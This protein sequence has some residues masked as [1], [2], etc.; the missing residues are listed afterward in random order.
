MLLCVKVLVLC[1]NVHPCATQTEPTEAPFDGLVPQ[2]RDPNT[3]ILKFS[4]LPI[5]VLDNTSF[6]RYANVIGI[7]MYDCSITYVKSGT[8]SAHWRLQVVSLQ[9]NKI[10]EFS[11]NFG[12]A[13]QSIIKIMLWAAFSLRRLQP[14][15]FKKFPKL[16]Y[17]NLGHNDWTPFDPSIL[18][19]GLTSINLNYAYGLTTFPN[20]TNWTPNLKI[21]NI[22]RNII[23][24]IPPDNVRNMTINY[25]NIGGNRLT[26]IP[27]YN[28]Y[29]YINVLHLQ[30][31]KLTTVPDF[32]N[33]TLKQLRIELNPLVCDYA[34]CWIRMW[35]WMFDTPL[36]ADTPIC[37]SPASVTGT[38]LME[39]HPIHME[40]FNGK[41]GN[42]S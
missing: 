6:V 37:A 18:P 33:T 23:Q 17:L 31:N 36:L 26:S 3:T 12:L 2:D 14:F 34:L 25:I 32:Y 40:C 22:Y 24:E 5:P 19:I 42:H 7:F 9:R 41:Y 8:F 11:D 13:T 1:I 27:G 15:L 21:I 38:P 29:P 39:V 16:I 10:I 4:K 28:V 30:A 20:F 35:P